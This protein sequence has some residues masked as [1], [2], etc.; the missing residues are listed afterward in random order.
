M[1]VRYVMSVYPETLSP[2]LRVMFAEQI[3]LPWIMM[4]GIGHLC[5]STKRVEYS[6]NL[7]IIEVYLDYLYTI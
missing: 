4:E 1:S 2:D 6:P 3:R 7:C 5:Y